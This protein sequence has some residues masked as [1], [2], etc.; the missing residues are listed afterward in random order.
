[1]PQDSWFDS[2]KKLDP[3]STLQLDPTAKSRG[4]FDENAPG[5]QEI[6]KKTSGV[7][8]PT[9][10]MID[11]L[12]PI[13]A[14]AGASAAG[15]MAAPTVIGSAPAAIGTYALIDGILQKLRSEPDQSFASEN[16]GLKPGSIPATLANTG[17]QYLL[18]KAGEKIFTGAA[19]VIKGFNSSDVPEIYKYGPTTSQAA[20]SEG[21][22][23]TAKVAKFV[24]D[25]FA[26]GAKKE[27]QQASAALLDKEASNIGYKIGHDFTREELR[28]PS[29]TFSAMSKEIPPENI[30]TP[31]SFNKTKSPIRVEAK[32]APIE[33]TYA[34]SYK[35]LDKIITDSG[36]LQ[37]MLTHAQESGGGTNLRSDVGA[38]KFMRIWQDAIKRDPIDPSK[39]KLDPQKLTDSLY[40]PEFQSSGKLLWNSKQRGDIEQFF[41]NVAYTQDKINAHPYFRL[42]TNGMAFTGNIMMALHGNLPGAAMGTTIQ[43]G[44]NGVGKL[45]TNPKVSRL[46]VS[47][48]G[49]EP[50]GVSQEYAARAIVNALNGMTVAI[51]NRDGSSTPGT[52]R[53]G[54]FEPSSQQ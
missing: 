23:K 20:A 15:T 25:T 51:A 36:K 34:D 16:L 14:G 29:Q 7:P 19:R 27:A 26:P 2:V 38:Y 39:M 41:K 28:D 1:M 32:G 52:V 4:W 54:R 24:E 46:L 48:A 37:K 18:N 21:L 43:L 49:G 53:E 42:G 3:S 40:D 10:S 13:V 5:A 44:A 35:D 50:L 33:T 9:D 12:R 17:Q 45:L 47:M 8:R 22:G 31:V 11:F 30:Y 6:I